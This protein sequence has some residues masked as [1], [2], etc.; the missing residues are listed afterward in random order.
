MPVEFQ[1]TTVV[2]EWR[3][4]E[5]PAKNSLVLNK[6]SQSALEHSSIFL[7]LYLYSKIIK[8][9]KEFSMMGM[10]GASLQNDS[11]MT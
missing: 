3:H 6:V 9:A 11:Q 4:L 10:R 2:S 1:L 5:A 7:H 8:E